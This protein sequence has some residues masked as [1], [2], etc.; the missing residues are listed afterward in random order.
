MNQAN[1][2]RG[3][4]QKYKRGVA[5]TSRL[6]CSAMTLSAWSKIQ[7]EYLAQWFFWI[8]T[9]FP[10]GAIHTRCDHVFFHPVCWFFQRSRARSRHCCTKEWEWWHC[11]QNQ[12]KQTPKKSILRETRMLSSCY[13]WYLR[14]D[15]FSHVLY[16]EYNLYSFVTELCDLKSTV[17]LFHECYE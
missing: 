14:T 5:P 13:L 6:Q 16:I 7:C 9:I 2:R 4:S 17:H 8:K 12:C 3:D 1:Q 10:V 11:F 15:L